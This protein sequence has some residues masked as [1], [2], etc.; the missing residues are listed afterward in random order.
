MNYSLTS[1]VALVTSATSGI[2][3]AA[4]LNFARLGASVVV[5]GRR[6]EQGIETV[7]LIEQEKGK[8]IFVKADISKSKDVEAMIAKAVE[9]CR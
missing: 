6:D 1:K 4:A 8:A 5:V 3:Q 2:G 9:T 7:R